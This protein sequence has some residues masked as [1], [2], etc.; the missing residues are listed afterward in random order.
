VLINKQYNNPAK[1]YLIGESVLRGTDSMAI[2]IRDMENPEKGLSAQPG[3]VNDLKSDKYKKFAFDCK[4]SKSNDNCGVHVLSG[5]PNRMSV[6]VMK[7]LSPAES[8]QLFYNVMTKRLQAN[9]QFVDYK[10]ALLEECKALPGNA[11]QV[12]S[13]AL[14][15]V[16]L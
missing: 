15:Q 2:A 8:T 13:N 5:I 10:A 3:H 7:A 11:C 4:P 6:F 12:V 1:P 14:E 9:S 16:G